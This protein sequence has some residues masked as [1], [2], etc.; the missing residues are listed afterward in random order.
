MV[1]LTAKH[2][3][4]CD[5]DLIMEAAGSKQRIA[6]H[7]LRALMH[8]V[9]VVNAQLDSRVMVSIIVKILMNARRR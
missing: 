3:E 6:G 1:I 4:Y 7:F 8:T 5:A 9:G 2:L